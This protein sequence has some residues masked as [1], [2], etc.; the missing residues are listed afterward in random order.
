MIDTFISIVFNFILRK[1]EAQKQREE[2]YRPQLQVYFEKKHRNS[3]RLLV[4]NV[5]GSPAYQLKATCE[6]PWLKRMFKPH[7][8]EGLNSSSTSDDFCWT[9]FYTEIRPGQEISLWRLNHTKYTETGTDDTNYDN[10]FD[11]SGIER[12]LMREQPLRVA[13][14]YE[15]DKKRLYKDPPFLANPSEVLFRHFQFDPE[16]TKIFSPLFVPTEADYE[17]MMRFIDDTVALHLGSASWCVLTRKDSSGKIILFEDT[18]ELKGYARDFSNIIPDVLDGQYKNCFESLDNTSYDSLYDRF[19]EAVKEI[20]I[21]ILSFEPIK[22]YLVGVRTCNFL[23]KHF[24]DPNSEER[25]KELQELDKECEIIL[26]KRNKGDLYADDILSLRYF[27]E[28]HKTFFQFDSRIIP[29]LARKF[30]KNIKEAPNFSDRRSITVSGSDSHKVDEIMKRIFPIQETITE[31][32][33]IDG[34]KVSPGR[35]REDYHS[36]ANI[37]KKTQQLLSKKDDIYSKQLL[38][39]VRELKSIFNNY[40]LRYNNAAFQ[41]LQEAE[42]SYIATKEAFKDEP[43]ARKRQMLKRKFQSTLFK[44]ARLLSGDEKYPSCEESTNIKKEFDEILEDF[45]KDTTATQPTSDA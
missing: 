11:S 18:I 30:P 44:F 29:E 39:F 35:Y 1:K 13:L 8:W 33:Y 5:G 19:I 38:I 36:I 7:C 12:L 14:E 43:D 37:L 42:L 10:F 21:Q 25:K 9:P 27:R 23:D 4:K 32:T 41:T 15:D 16:D 3:L 40:R 17:E 31:K 20:W 28:F 24:P 34:C 26:N 2:A 6:A 45:K 22:D